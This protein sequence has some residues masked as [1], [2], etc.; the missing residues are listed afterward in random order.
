MWPLVLS[1]V[2]SLLIAPVIIRL[3]KSR[4]WVDDPHAS[5]HAKKTHF[6]PVPRGGGMVVYAGI[7]LASLIF[8]Q[9]DKYLIGI[10]LGGLIL[11]I[12]GVLDDIYDIHPL[13][14]L[15]INFLAALVV[16]GSGIGIA[17]VSNPF[18]PG[19][20]HL[21]Q[22]QLPLFLFG[23]T[24]TIWILADLFALIFIVWNMNIVNWAKGV[25]GQLPGFVS[26]AAIMIGVL[27]YQ[28]IDDP[29][30]FNTAHLSFIV[31]GAYLGLL[32]WNWY[33][34]KM[35]PGYGAGSLA[36]YLLS[37]L[38]ILSGAKVATTLMVL[39]IPTADAIFTIGR[40]IVAGKSP[41]WGD[42]GHLH[43]KLMDVLGWGR[44]RIAI[45]YWASSFGLGWLSLHLQT[46][47]K[48]VTLIVVMS[49]VFGFLIWAKLKQLN[50]DE[51]LN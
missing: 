18:G 31:A 48:I 36:G 35:M 9:I 11:V 6:F 5:R 23:K 38:A 27:S 40:R 46:W 26:I 13:L 49:L 47:G 51:D 21:N 14:R 4:N 45:F 33:P 25:D 10:L 17:Y 39:A 24:R 50:Q 19:V 7:L 16:V 12:G 1:T 32:Y 20:I 22:P 30:Q 29:T 8:L 3:Y 28:F 37:I 2:T 41:F 34:Q 15:G 43:H 42:R 44:Q